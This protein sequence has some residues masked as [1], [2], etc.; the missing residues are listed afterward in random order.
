MY[1][2]NT[3]LYILTGL[4]LGIAPP[5]IALHLLQEYQPI[6]SELHHTR[7]SRELH[8]GNHDKRGDYK[9]FD[10][11][12][13]DGSHRAHG[14]Q[15]RHYKKSR[16]T[17]E[18]LASVNGLRFTKKLFAAVLSEEAHETKMSA[19]VG[20]TWGSDV[21]DFEFMYATQDDNVFPHKSTNHQNKE[22]VPV[23]GRPLFIL[24][25]YLVFYTTLSKYFSIHG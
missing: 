20:M 9:D 1:L 6:S 18:A 15:Q 14:K 2:K 3:T 11:A 17:L 19:A 16:N 7:Q 5:L 10:K 21:I 12:I 25:I 8:L 4:V 24:I 22:K 13:S 23:P